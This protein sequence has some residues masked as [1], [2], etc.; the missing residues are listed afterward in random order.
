MPG[1]SALPAK[2]SVKASEAQSASERSSNRA[3]SKACATRRGSR[4]GTGKIGEKQ[5]PRTPRTARSVSGSPGNSR[6][7]LL[8][9]RSDGKPAPGS[10]QTGARSEIAAPGEPTDV[11][12]G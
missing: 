8:S 7:K 11:L 1:A 5:A 2:I 9:N 4:T 6:T 10:S 12:L 3:T